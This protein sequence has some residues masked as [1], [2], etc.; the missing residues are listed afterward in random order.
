M[1]LV[2]N[3]ASAKMGGALRYISSLLEYLP[4]AF[5]DSEIV[6]LLPPETAAKLENVSPNVR[7]APVAISHA[8]WWRRLWWD[9]VTLRRLVRKEK[10]DALFAIG[11]FGLWHCPARQV[12]LVNNALYFSEAYWRLCV[13][14]HPLRRR[15]ELR[16]RRWLA[17]NSARNADVV[18]LPSEAMLCELGRFV[19]VGN[20]QAL[21][22]PYGTAETCD[23]PPRRSAAKSHEPVRLLF[24]S[25]Y[26]EHKNLAT[27]LRAMPILN[28]S[29]SCVFEL[30]TLANPAWENIGWSR[31][32][33]GDLELARR[34]DVSKHVR[35]A[36][37]LN[38]AETLRL[39]GQADVVVFPSFVESFGFPMVE[40]MAH[41]LPIVAADTPINRE[42][43]QDAAVY[44]APFDEADLA[45]KILDV[46]RD[47][48]L[49]ASM[50]SA[51][52]RRVAGHFRWEAHVQRLAE[53]ISGE[54]S[55]ER[56]WKGRAARRVEW[57]LRSPSSF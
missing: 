57:E 56:A 46:H 48:D 36:G 43:C 10:A 37:P 39:Y 32:W 40:A 26:A 14:K 3:A 35:L 22:N 44:F 19:K 33:Q 5:A 29:A 13:S 2:I 9:W 53:A 25:L 4:G 41:G 17:I 30:T 1:K 49:R 28:A 18:M 34:P 7:L 47:A 24:V 21:V 20:G 23:T 52:P 8:S 31:T 12:L 6:V 27:L 55:G 42:I 50:A 11:N 54:E 38:H 16:L 51:G 15:I 45:R